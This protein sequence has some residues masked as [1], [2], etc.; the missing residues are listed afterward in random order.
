MFAE[1]QAFTWRDSWYA[2]VMNPLKF[3]P[4]HPASAY[5]FLDLGG[6][7]QLQPTWTSDKELGSQVVVPSEATSRGWR[8]TE[9]YKDWD[10]VQ[11]GRSG[12]MYR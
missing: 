8:K 1:Y 12:P 9:N 5:S 2:V 4:S 6:Q 11:D 3:L 7:G 10:S